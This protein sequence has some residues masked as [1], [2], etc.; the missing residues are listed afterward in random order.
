VASGER[1]SS[2]EVLARKML[3]PQVREKT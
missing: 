3:S 1:L 2:S